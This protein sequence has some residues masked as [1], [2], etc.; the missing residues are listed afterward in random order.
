M[1][2]SRDCEHYVR[3]RLEANHSLFWT[4]SHRLFLSDLLPNHMS[5]GHTI[6][7]AQLKFKIHRT[8]IKGGCL[9]GRKV[10]T[11]NSKSGL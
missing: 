10:G 4:D 9:S 7:H 2:R 11:H 5:I 3:V 1:F 6:A 8:K